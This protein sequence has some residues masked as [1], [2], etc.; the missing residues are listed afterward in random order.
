M[1]FIK[2]S[3]WVAKY[4]DVV[5]LTI[6][7]FCWCSRMVRAWASI[8]KRQR[9]IFIHQV[10]RPR[11]HESLI[12]WGSAVVEVHGCDKGRDQS[13]EGRKVARAGKAMS[14]VRAVM[15]ANKK[16]QMPRKITSRGISPAT[17]L[18]I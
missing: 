2:A 18:M 3:Y 10:V 17:P 6:S 11:P 15:M 12:N 14:R 9:T 5:L 16:G 7:A 13:R 1:T 4:S 8:L